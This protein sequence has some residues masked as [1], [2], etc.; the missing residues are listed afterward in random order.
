MRTINI[1]KV[2]SGTGVVAYVIMSP[3]LSTEGAF[4]Q[5]WPASFLKSATSDTWTHDLE[6]AMKY[7]SWEAAEMALSRLH[8]YRAERTWHIIEDDD[9]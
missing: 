2:E 3:A 7:A 1:V 6:P 4:V 8:K 9:E 5:Y